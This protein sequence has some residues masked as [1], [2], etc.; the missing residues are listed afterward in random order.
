[1]T[2]II[3]DKDT[4]RSEILLEKKMNISQH[5][6]Y[7]CIRKMY[8]LYVFT[9]QSF[10]KLHEAKLTKLK[11]EIDNSTKLFGVSIPIIND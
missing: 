9:H 8:Q 6:N 7:Q 3:S 10:P 1:M 4:L 2:K 11:N 5:K